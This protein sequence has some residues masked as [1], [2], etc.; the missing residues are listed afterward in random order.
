MVIAADHHACTA[1]AES[2]G[3]SN[4]TSNTFGM[5]AEVQRANLARIP[6]DIMKQLNKLRPRTANVAAAAAA[7]AEN[8]SGDGSVAESAEGIFPFFSHLIGL[9]VDTLTVYASNAR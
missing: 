9:F 7:S 2:E 6:A 5:P 3:A 4:F 8:E 1:Y